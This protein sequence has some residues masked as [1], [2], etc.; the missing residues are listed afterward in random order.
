MQHY[1]V[2]RM[3]GRIA[4]RLVVMEELEFCTGSACILPGLRPLWDGW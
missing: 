2:I 3:R 4:T 1:I